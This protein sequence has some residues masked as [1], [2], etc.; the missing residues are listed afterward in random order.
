[1]RKQACFYD[2]RN[3]DDFILKLIVK[4]PDMEIILA[5]TEY[6]GS[7]REM[8]TMVNDRIRQT[9]PEEISEMDELI[10]PKIHLAVNHTYK[11]LIGK[12]LANRGFRDYFF[13]EAD[14]DVGFSLDE[15]GA[16][17]EATGTIVKMKGPVPRIYAIDKPFLLI[18]RRPGSME[19]DLV[20][21]VANADFLVPYA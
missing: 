13:A 16:T 6:Q 18:L 21:W 8:I 20:L 19:P 2:Y 9:C 12:F 7:V 1:M 15:T 14:Q 10:I 17:A 5:K 4:E 11:E 3:P